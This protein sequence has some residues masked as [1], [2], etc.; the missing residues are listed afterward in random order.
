MVV[1]VLD[2]HAELGA[3]VAEVVLADHVG[4]EEAQH[5]DQAV[6]DDGRAQV[7]DVHLFGDVRP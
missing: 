5:A 2:Q 1:E 7:T 3:P 6:T 4:A